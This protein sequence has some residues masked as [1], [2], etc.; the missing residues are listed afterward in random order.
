PGEPA[1]ADSVTAYTI[2]P[3][4]ISRILCG[5]YSRQQKQQ[6][7]TIRPYPLKISQRKP[8]HL[9]LPVILP[10]C[11]NEQCRPASSIPGIGSTLCRLPATVHARSRGCNPSI[12]D[13]AP[14]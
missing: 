9:E 13:P 2:L 5:R 1:A 3:K 8:F 7:D 14:K 6:Q 12:R 4:E 10:A 11:R